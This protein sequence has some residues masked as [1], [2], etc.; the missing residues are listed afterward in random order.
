MNSTFSSQLKQWGLTW[1]HGTGFYLKENKFSVELSKRFKK[2]IGFSE[3]NGGAFRVVS[4]LQN[5]GLLLLNYIAIIIN[6]NSIQHFSYKYVCG[7][8]I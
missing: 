1:S 4:Y 6:N 7:K 8:V 2:V 5:T 3:E